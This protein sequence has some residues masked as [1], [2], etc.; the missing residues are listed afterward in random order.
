MSDSKAEE[1][2]VVADEVAKGTKRSAEEASSEVSAITKKVCEELK[3]ENELL[4]ELIVEQLG[5]EEAEKL[6]A[7]AQ[8]VEKSEEGIKTADGSRRK[9]PGGVYF[10][11]A[12]D[13]I[14]AGKFNVLTA[15]VR[16][17]R[18]LEKKANEQDKPKE[19]AKE[20][21]AKE[22]AAK[23]EETKEE[24]AKEEENKE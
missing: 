18:K 4:V 8:E 16:K 7:K 13:A 21:A 5:A 2:P 23:E 3:E 1:T 11:L 19:E 17:Q 14:G 20:E 15:R 9:T 10:H 22:E 24:A 6:L 12:K